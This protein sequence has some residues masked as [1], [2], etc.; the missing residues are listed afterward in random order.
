MSC[1]SCTDRAKGGGTEKESK[2]ITTGDG[3]RDMAAVLGHI[4]PFDIQNDDWSLY[5]ERL[6]Q[7]YIANEIT[8]NAKKVAVLLTVIGT[9]AYELLHSLLAPELPST[10]SYDE[11]V[12]VLEDHLKPKPLVIAER[13]KFHHRNQKDGETVAQYVAALRKLTEHCDFK[14]YLDEAL[15]DRLVCG[16]RSEV[17]QRKLLSEK[18]L[19]FQRAYELAHSLETANRQASELQATTRAAVHPP[20]DVQVVAPGNPTSTSVGAPSCHRCGK[21]GHAQDKCYYRLQKCRACGKRGHIA[22]MCKSSSQGGTFGRDRTLP[23]GNSGHRA[24]HVEIKVPSD[25]PCESTQGFEAVGLFTVQMAEGDPEAP[26][27]LHPEVNGVTLAME[28]DTGASVSL[29]S[30]RV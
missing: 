19:G 20:R 15:R 25:S 1:D 16:L 5:I 12:K 22:K 21:M 27:T 28:L 26:I 11:L 29:I 10:K 2:N 3:G 7:F 18:T 4:E 8:T 14:D 13:F 6:G 23:G 17:I 9:K 30:E 24:G